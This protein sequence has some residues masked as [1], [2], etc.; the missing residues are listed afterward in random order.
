MTTENDALLEAQLRQ[1]LAPA[2]E[3]GGELRARI[4]AGLMDRI[5]AMAAALPPHTV[6]PYR[7][8]PKRDYPK[9]TPIEVYAD[10]EAPG[11]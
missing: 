1:A 2:G 6:V 11:R 8:I 7:N 10:D 9:N 5:T 4:C 3:P